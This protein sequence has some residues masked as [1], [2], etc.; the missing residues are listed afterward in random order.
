MCQTNRKRLCHILKWKLYVFTFSRFLIAA[1]SST[2]ASLQFCFSPFHGTVI[3]C[4]TGVLIANDNFAGTPTPCLDG[5][6]VGVI[7]TIALADRW[8]HTATAI[9][10]AVV[11][12][13]FGRAHWRI[14][15]VRRIAVTTAVGW[16]VGARIAFVHVLSRI[17]GG[18]RNA[19]R[20]FTLELWRRRWWR[21][22]L[23]TWSLYQFFR[24]LDSP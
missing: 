18:A 23:I 11:T 2:A 12:R 1:P 16:F 3:S 22:H 7:V 9:V 20:L 24:R 14:G 8:R 19:G 15:C 5:T 10:F 4:I 6:E 17:L 13:Q 21:L